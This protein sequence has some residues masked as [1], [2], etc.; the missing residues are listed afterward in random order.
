MFRLALAL[1]RTV[2]ELEQ[3][4][5][6]NELREWSVFAET[7]PFGDVRADFRSAMV[8][9]VI[10]KVNGNKHAKPTDFMPFYHRAA[11]AASADDKASAR[12]L[13]QRFHAEFAKATR[14]KTLRVIR[15]AK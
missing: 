10:A 14:G 11:A 6:I 8:A 3:T 13:S 15:K 9:T 5:S 1:G 2:G 7:E 12:A 4:M